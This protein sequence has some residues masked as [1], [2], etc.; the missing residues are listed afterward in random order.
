MSIRDLIRDHVKEGRLHTLSPALP[1]IPVVRHMFVTNDVLDALDTSIWADDPKARM[2]GAQL[3]ADLD[4]F[5]MGDPITVAENPY[6]KPA[7][8]YIA[9]TDPVRDQVW[10]IR[11]RDPKPSIRVLG[12]FAQ[13]DC[14]V[15]L[16]W[17]LRTNLGGPD[18]KEWRDF[19]VRCKATWRNLFH[20]YQPHSGGQI[21]DYISHN[22]VAV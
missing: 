10:D 6:S 13:T 19:I 21:S 8:T 12:C 7:S 15:A 16:A 2:R 22:T 17:D 11:S 3:R 5:T 20:T 14:F 18:S 9:R 1:S 4:R